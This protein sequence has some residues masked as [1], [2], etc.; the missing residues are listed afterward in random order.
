MGLHSLSL[1]LLLKILILHTLFKACVLLP[2]ATE[3]VRPPCP[4]PSPLSQ[5]C[6]R[7]AL[8]STAAMPVCTQAQALRHSEGHELHTAM[9][10]QTEARRAEA[11]M[12][13]Q[14]KQKRRCDEETEPPEVVDARLGE[15]L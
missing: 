4:S 10:Q 1:L 7:C 14:R 15:T 2:P 8:L 12:R 11:S 6:C 3:A 9:L 13:R 5:R